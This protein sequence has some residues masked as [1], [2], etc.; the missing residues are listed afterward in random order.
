T[1][2]GHA[3]SVEFLVAGVER[4]AVADREPEHPAR[5]DCEQRSE[6]CSIAADPW[7]GSIGVNCRRICYR[8][9]CG[10]QK[11]TGVC[12]LAGTGATAMVNRR[13]GQA[14]GHQQAGKPL[15]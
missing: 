14:A 4:P 7:S 8:E 13:Q 2:P 15:S 12:G 5:T 6:L 1:E 9:W 3:S 11:R 10:F